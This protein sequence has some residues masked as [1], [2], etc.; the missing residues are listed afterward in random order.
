[1]SPLSEAIMVVLL[2]G[3]VTLLT[4]F[5]TSG[6]QWRKWRTG[7]QQKVNADGASVLTGA[8]I[9]LVTEMRQARDDDK[10]EIA[11]LR[12]EIE[13]LR[14]ELSEMEDVRDWAERLYYQVKSMGG[15]PVKIRERKTVKHG[16]TEDVSKP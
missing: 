3:A 6:T 9:D 8:S 2:S 14:S 16:G 11:V 13:K 15:V 7:E 4:S 1:M 10:R 12:T 5:L